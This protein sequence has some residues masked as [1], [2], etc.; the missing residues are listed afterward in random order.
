MFFVW[1]QTGAH[2]PGRP[3]AKAL[4]YL[5]AP[6]DSSPPITTC[7]VLTLTNVSALVLTVLVGLVGW[8]CGEE[9]DEAFGEGGVGDDEV[10]D[11]GVGQVVGHG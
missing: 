8:D 5:E 11:G 1:T 10:A 7:L 3:K 2:T 6:T 4:G 9:A